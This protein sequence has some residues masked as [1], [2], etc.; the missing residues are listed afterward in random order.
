MATS[1][2]FGGTCTYNLKS[3]KT[4]RDYFNLIN[5]KLEIKIIIINNKRKQICKHVIIYY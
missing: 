5:D 1:L 3:T 4:I 2:N